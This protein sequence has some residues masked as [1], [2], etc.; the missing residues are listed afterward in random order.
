MSQNLNKMV[1]ILLMALPLSNLS[2]QVKGDFSIS[3]IN[4]EIN[5][6]PQI[7]TETIAQT[8]LIEDIEKSFTIFESGDLRFVAT[9]EFSRSGKRVKLTR[10]AYVQRGIEKP[11]RGKKKK[12][13]QFINVGVPGTIS[14]QMSETLLIDKES[15]KSIFVN[16]IY[17]FKYK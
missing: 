11:V 4:V 17:I 12:D 15:M 14:S 6:E 2:A 16:F 10:S 5:N 8:H 9:F 7:P 1:V 13:V 3:D